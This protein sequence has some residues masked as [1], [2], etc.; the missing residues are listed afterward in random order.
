MGNETPTGRTS[1][2]KITARFGR[3]GLSRERPRLRGTG[4]AARFE[5]DEFYI[6]W[7]DVTETSIVA[8]TSLYK[9]CLAFWSSALMPVTGF[10]TRIKPWASFVGSI[11]A[12]FY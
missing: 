7:L 12:A 6:M 11:P 8:M 2:G 9:S 4:Q 3:P 10:G 1:N 5:R